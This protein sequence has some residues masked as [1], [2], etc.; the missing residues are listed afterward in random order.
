MYNFNGQI[1]KDFQIS[2]SQNRA[3]LYGDAVFETIRVNQNTILFIEDHYFRLMASMRILRMEIPM[4]FTLEFFEDQ[5]LNLISACET[6]NAFRVRITVFRD[7][8][9]FYVPK[10]NTVSY[11]IHA[12][13][14]NSDTYTILND[15]YEIELFKDFSIN[16]Q[17]LSTLKSTNRMVQITAGIFAKEN[18]YDNCLILNTDKNV[19]EAIDSNLFMVMGN[20]IITPPLADG[21]L[22]GILRKQIIRELE[23]N[24]DFTL[25]EKSISPFDLQKA[26]ELFLTNVIKGIQPITKYR[27][28]IFTSVVATKILDILNASI[29]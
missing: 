14:L 15:S 9:G 12:Q 1:A 11:L 4:F 28:K 19:A 21:C 22:N 24:T 6:S 17:L 3:F 2:V 18:A 13:P 26:D 5:I 29:N 27:K 10:T 7:A 20:T 16:A 8:E 23:K 25:V